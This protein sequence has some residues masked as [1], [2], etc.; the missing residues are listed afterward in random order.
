MKRALSASVL[1]LVFLAGIPASVAAKQN[2]P[3]VSTSIPST[4]ARGIVHTTAGK[5]AGYNEHGS[6]N[7]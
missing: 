2:T 6:S 7:F 3:A 4:H 1:G 5:V